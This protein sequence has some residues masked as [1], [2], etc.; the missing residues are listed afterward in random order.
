MLYISIIISATILRI[1]KLVIRPSWQCINGKRGSVSL[2]TRKM[3]TVVTCPSVHYSFYPKVGS[4]SMSVVLTWMNSWLGSH[5]EYWVGL[6]WTAVF[7][8][9]LCFGPS[10]VQQAPVQYGHAQ[11]PVFKPV[12]NTKVIQKQS[13]ERLDNGNQWTVTAW[14]LLPLRHIH[15]AT[16]INHDRHQ[17]GCLMYG[18]KSNRWHHEY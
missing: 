5:A 12:N 4:L 13:V 8:R 15:R 1:T 6:H 9:M 18:R 7:V 3:M 14:R 17:S 2:N 10:G 16:E 11:Y